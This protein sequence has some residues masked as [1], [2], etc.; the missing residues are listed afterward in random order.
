[1]IATARCKRRLKSEV[2][3]FGRRKTFR[4]SAGLRSCKTP[5]RQGLPSSNQHHAK[6]EL[7]VVSDRT[8]RGK[9]T[10]LRLPHGFTLNE[11]TSGLADTLRHL[12]L[13]LAIHQARSRQSAADH[14]CG[15]Q[16]CHRLRHYFSTHSLPSHFFAA[17]PS[18]V[19]ITRGNRRVVVHTELR[20][21]LL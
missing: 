3:L 8:P 14:V 7:L 2:Q 12:G 1:M 5:R 10:R 4:I 6:R 11:S 20:L 13:H 17:L 18:R 16:V 9:R 15:H 21:D 19:A